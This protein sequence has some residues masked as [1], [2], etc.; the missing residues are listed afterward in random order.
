VG[1]PGDDL[2]VLVLHEHR[3]GV[4]GVGVV[5]GASPDLSPASTDSD[6]T[7]HLG[8]VFSCERARAAA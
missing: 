7:G 8:L 3:L 2:A 6:A 4:A 1:L 5:A